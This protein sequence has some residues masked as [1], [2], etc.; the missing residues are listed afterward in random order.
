MIVFLYLTIVNAACFAAF[1]ID[2][3]A[4]RAGRW[5]IAERHLLGL[6]LAGG[7]GGALLGQLWLRHKTRKEPF[8]SQLVAILLLQGAC[9]LFWITPR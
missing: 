3:A 8:R 4:A 6:A 2:K 5:R 7:S 1:A 9:L